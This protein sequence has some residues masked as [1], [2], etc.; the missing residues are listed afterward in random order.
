MGGSGASLGR[1]GGGSG[2]TVIIALRSGG[3]G[4]HKEGE[5]NE[6]LHVE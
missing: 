1:V 6:V 2:A 5:G 4:G 3:G